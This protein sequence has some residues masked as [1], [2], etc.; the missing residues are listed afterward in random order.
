MI[1]KHGISIF[2]SFQKQEWKFFDY[3]NVEMKADALYVFRD[4]GLVRSYHVGET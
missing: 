4:M 1:T 2:Y 3:E